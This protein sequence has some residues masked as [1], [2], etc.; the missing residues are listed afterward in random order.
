[1]TVQALIFDLGGVV[2]ES[3]FHVIKLFAKE[4]QLEPEALLECFTET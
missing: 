3:P 1:M 4:S 2:L